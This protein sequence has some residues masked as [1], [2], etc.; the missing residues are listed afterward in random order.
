MDEYLE[1]RVSSATIWSRRLAMFSGVLLLIAGAGHRFGYLATPDLAP[2]LVVVVAIVFLSLL[3]ASRALYLFWH[4]GG[5]GGPMLL[6]AI[7]IALLVLSPFGVTAWRGLTLPVLN[8]VS[9]DTDDPPELAFAADERDEGM[10]R[11]APFTAER[12]RLQHASYPRATGRRY[13]APIG[14]VAEVVADVLEKRGWP[15][16]GSDDFPADATEITFE[17]EAASLFLGFPADVAIR[18]ID[19]DTSTYVDMRSASRYGPHDFG[20]NA[21][22]IASFLAELDM[23]VAYLSVASPSAPPAPEQP[24]VP[25]ERPEDA[26]D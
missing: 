19:E 13:G 8:D 2:V 23:E 4:Y 24:P 9:T 21:A 25:S 17:A 3:S 18:L 15:L 10:N 7:L 14:Q 6:A 11:I 26:A 1:R 16:A 5:K 22:R 20:D 12:R